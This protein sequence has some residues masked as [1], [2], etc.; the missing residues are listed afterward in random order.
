MGES[1]FGSAHELWL[2]KTG[3][4][5]PFAGN[6]ATQRGID[7]EPEIKRLFEQRI[8]C[9]LAAPVLEYPEWPILSASLDGLNQEQKILAEFKFPSKEKHAMALR[10]EIP[11]TYLAQL[12]TQMLVTGMDNCF[13]VSYDGSGIAVVNYA[14]DKE[15]QARIL[16]KCR[17]FWACVTE[18]REPD[19][20]VSF[21]TG[22]DLQRA[23]YRYRDLMLQRDGIELELE[24]L[25]KI[26]TEMVPDKKAEF[27]GLAL[28]RSMRKG[29]VD[30]SKIKGIDFESYRKPE[31]EVVSIRAL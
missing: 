1:D 23:A 18:D 22:D 5:I 29:A 30:Y 13:Y 20:G 31:I 12:Q 4:K 11:K 2:V 17:E 15:Y 6:A 8:G 16:E 14:S 21:P 27:Y 25:K 24:S 26:I 28:T 19:R 7:A 9:E 10:G 3:K